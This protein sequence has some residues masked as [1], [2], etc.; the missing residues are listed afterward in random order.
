MIEIASEERQQSNSNGKNKEPN[1]EDEIGESNT[2]NVHRG[3][4]YK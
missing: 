4:G 3:G 1:K 2:I